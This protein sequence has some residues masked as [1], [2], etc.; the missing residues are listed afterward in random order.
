MSGK[1]QNVATTPA[2][3]DKADTYLPDNTCT[4]TRTDDTKC[5]IY[6]QPRPWLLVD[7]LC[8]KK[9]TIF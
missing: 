2:L 6:R 9:I 8:Y 1:P 4:Y 5:C 3:T 7:K